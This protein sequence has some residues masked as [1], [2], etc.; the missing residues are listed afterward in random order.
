MTKQTTDYEKN[1][2]KYTSAKNLSPE[3][4]SFVEF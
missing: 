2:C 4:V 1:A 3:Y